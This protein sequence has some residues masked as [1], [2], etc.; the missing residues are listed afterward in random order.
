VKEYEHYFIGT[1]DLIVEILSNEEP[2]FSQISDG[3][4]VKFTK[5]EAGD[6]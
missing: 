2:I 1:Y 5:R 3:E 6:L 4:V